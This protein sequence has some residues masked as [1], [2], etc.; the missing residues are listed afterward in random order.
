MLRRQSQDKYTGRESMIAQYSREKLNK[1]H[2]PKQLY[3][4]LGLS[5]ED[6]MMFKINSSIDINRKSNLSP[7]EK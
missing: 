4:K 5:K 2:S 1:L 7:Y 6:K 3:S